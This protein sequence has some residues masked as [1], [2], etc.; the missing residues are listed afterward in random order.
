VA[1]RGEGDGERREG[2]KKWGNREAE[3]GGGIEREE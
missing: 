1:T 3:V 2:V